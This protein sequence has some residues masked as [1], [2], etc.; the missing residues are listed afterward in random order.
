[1]EF[2]VITNNKRITGQLNKKLAIIRAISSFMDYLN[3]NIFSTSFCEKG[4]LLSQWRGY[5]SYSSACSI[6][7]NTKMLENLIIDNKIPFKL[8]KCT[9]SCD[10]RYKRTIM[11][12]IDEEIYNA[13]NNYDDKQKL[14]SADKPIR[15]IF[16]E[17]FIEK[18]SL[19]KLN[20]FKEESEWRLISTELIRYDDKKTNYRTGKTTIIPYYTI[21]L[22]NL[23]SIK[24]IIIGPNQNYE[25]TKNSVLGLAV[26]NSML[27]N[28]FTPSNIK[29]SKIPYRS[30]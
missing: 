22:G 7:F 6:G 20:C 3:A 10:S 12:Y 30:I 5:G 25:L 29:I 4:D 17:E 24:E 14:I 19:M 18:V 26:K 9:Y 23:S 21:P 16:I 27:S 15:K 13:E 1:L 2:N 11:K 8:N 28:N